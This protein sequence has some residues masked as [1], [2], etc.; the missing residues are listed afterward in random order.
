MKSSVVVSRFDT[1]TS[2][3]MLEP[4]NFVFHSL[5]EILGAVLEYQILARV[6]LR[7]CFNVDSSPFQNSSWAERRR[8]TASM[9]Q[10][11]M[12]VSGYEISAGFLLGLSICLFLLH[13][14]FAHQVLKKR[15]S[16]EVLCHNILVEVFR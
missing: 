3:E 14:L 16:P 2:L 12:G 9:N 15:T 11:N 6:G 13:T 5:Q 4:K 7:V 8:I 1:G 10:S